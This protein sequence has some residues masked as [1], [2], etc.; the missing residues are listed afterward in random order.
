MV[1]E[2]PMLDETGV[3]DDDVNCRY[4]L[5]PVA[6]NLLVQSQT[7]RDRERERVRERGD[8]S[9][10]IATV[11]QKGRDRQPRATA[12]HVYAAAC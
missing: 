2:K 9:N 3:S 4:R 11:A 8:S 12:D 1:A 7:Q 5:E 10:R 6:V